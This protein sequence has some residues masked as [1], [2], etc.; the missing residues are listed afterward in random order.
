MANPPKNSQTSL[1]DPLNALANVHE[2]IAKTESNPIYRKRRLK[3]A[4]R[5]RELAEQ[6]PDSEA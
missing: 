5:A 2:R 4:D 6:E 1:R 3:L